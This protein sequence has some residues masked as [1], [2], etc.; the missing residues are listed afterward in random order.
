MC[1]SAFV[2]SGKK[3]DLATGCQ[4]EGV[5]LASGHLYNVVAGEGVHQRGDK[6][7]HLY[8]DTCENLWYLKEA[9]EHSEIGLSLIE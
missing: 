1:K 6:P 9:K 5:S 2:N 4:E 7:S 8:C 3:K